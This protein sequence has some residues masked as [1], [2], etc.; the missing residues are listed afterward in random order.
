M[1]FYDFKHNYK[2]NISIDMYREVYF[3]SGFLLLLTEKKLGS[4]NN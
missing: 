3:L 4:T 2:Y 1:N